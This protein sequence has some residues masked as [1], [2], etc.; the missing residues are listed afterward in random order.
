M[1]NRLEKDNFSKLRPEFTSDDY[2]AEGGYTS[3]D[4]IIKHPDFLIFDFSVYYTLHNKNRFG[5]SISNLF[6]ENYTEK[7]GYNM[8]G[9]MITGT[10][11]YS[12]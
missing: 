6:D 11:V 9:R 7:D 2:F 8:P 1:G 4:K 10:F 3:K 12:F 5:I